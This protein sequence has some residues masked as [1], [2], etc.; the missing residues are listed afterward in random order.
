MSIE[1]TVFLFF[2][3]L[4]AGFIDSMAGGG[5]LITIPSLS[6]FLAMG[7]ECI[8][9][10]KIA[11]TGA[12][13]I[14]LLVY[15]LKGH[16]QW[17]QGGVFTLFIGLGALLGSSL[18]RWVSPAF[19]QGLLLFTCPVLLWV[20][21]NKDLWVQ[22]ETQLDSKENRRRFFLPVLGLLC[23][24]YDGLWGPGGGTLMFLS[25]F[26]VGKL[27]LFTA[28]AISKLSNTFSALLALLNFI[29]QGAV[30]WKLGLSL[31]AGVSFGALGGSLTVSRFK[32]QLIR[33][34]LVLVVAMLWLKVLFS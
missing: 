24:L 17:K 30:R 23:G 27:P 3:G 22:K 28:L 20:L 12:A 1:P 26:F 34:V 10:N 32:S 8:G 29:H 21:W 6:L 15:S 7:P 2:A 4:L 16:M 31:A 19:F 18:T 25:L 13:L 11:A 33:P 14:A 5:G 9:T